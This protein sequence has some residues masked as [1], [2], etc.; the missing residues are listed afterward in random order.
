LSTINPTIDELRL[1]VRKIY[2]FGLGFVQVKVSES[3]RY[4][5]YHWKVPAFVDEPHDH[6]YDFTSFVVRGEIWNKIWIAHPDGDRSGILENESCREGVDAPSDPQSVRLA[7]GSTFATLRG[8]SYSLHHASL[9]TVWPALNEGPC[10]TYVTRGP[11][12]KDFARVFHP[13]GSEKVCPF[14]KK[15][16]EDELWDIVSECLRY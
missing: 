4:N 11:I 6:R 7:M 3:A 2:Y 9:H 10:V 15:M 12:K 8:M 13:D 14:S 5:F 1:N 16:P